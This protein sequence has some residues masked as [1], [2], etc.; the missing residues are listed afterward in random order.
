MTHLA[1]YNKTVLSDKDPV[2]RLSSAGWAVLLGASGL[3][4]FLAPGLCALA[5][6]VKG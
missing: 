3:R 5:A 4:G 2:S 6:E 1:H